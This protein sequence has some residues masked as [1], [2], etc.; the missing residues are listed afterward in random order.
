[1]PIYRVFERGVDKFLRT[2]RAKTEAAAPGE[3][4]RLGAAGLPGCL[5]AFHSLLEVAARDGGPLDSRARLG[6]AACGR[7]SGF[8]ASR[9]AF[10]YVLVG[11]L[12]PVS[13]RRK[14]D[15]LLPQRIAAARSVPIQQIARFRAVER[16][17]AL[18]FRTGT[19]G[20]AAGKA[21]AAPGRKALGAC[22]C[23]IIAASDPRGKPTAAVERR[24]TTV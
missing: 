19:C 2:P 18:R 5:A 8:R 13:P 7:R 20:A 22:V 14:R 15:R 9:R 4:R 10:V 12:R 16:P 11:N 24:E 17:R 23:G 1:M 6:P 21:N 3:R